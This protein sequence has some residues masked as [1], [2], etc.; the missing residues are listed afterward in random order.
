M[1]PEVARL[2]RDSVKRKY[3]KHM[4][5]LRLLW[6]AVVVLLAALIGE[7]VLVLWFSPRFWINSIVVQGNDSLR[8]GDVV[9]LVA[10]H[11]P[12]SNFYRTSLHTLAHRVQQESRVES[13]Q[14]HRG[15]IGQLVVTVHERQAVCRIGYGRL[16]LYLDAAGV[17]FTRSP[18]PPL[19]VPVVEGLPPAVSTSKLGVPMQQPAVTNVLEALTALRD[20]ASSSNP[21]VVARVKIGAHGELTLVLRQGTRVY[22]G[23]PNDLTT[24]MRAMQQVIVRASADGF[25]LDQLAYI[26]VKVLEKLTDIGAAYKPKTTNAQEAV[27]Q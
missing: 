14:V 9:K 3:R 21:I 23:Y 11:N 22:L 2:R 4:R 17:L 1:N 13:A 26:D 10:L 12:R 7:V 16:P 15:A 27:Q 8:E 19:P 18:A 24:K 6:S 20:T 25:P 5:H